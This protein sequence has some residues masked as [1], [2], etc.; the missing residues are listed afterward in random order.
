[1]WISGLTLIVILA[2]AVLALQAL[3]R[4][5]PTPVWLERLDVEG[6]EAV[7][8]G[9]RHR[10]EELQALPALFR[11]E[12]YRWLQDQGFPE[13]AR[14]LRRQRVELARRY[15]AEL[16]EVFE[17]LHAL[18]ARLA[19]AV[20]PDRTAAAALS[21]RLRWAVAYWLLPLNRY[22]LQL[23]RLNPLGQTLT[24]SLAAFENLAV[25]A[26]AGA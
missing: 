12:D 18:H 2:L 4:Q 24:T 23:G 14:T 21:F 3:R 10:A 19:P 8:A 17:Q 22:R 13:A 16:R 6:P 1:M 7:L 9:L 25:P 5:G 15:L 26:L 11:D 20:E